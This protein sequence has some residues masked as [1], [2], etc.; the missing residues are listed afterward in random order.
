[1]S[2]SL[3]DVPGQAAQRVSVTEPRPGDP[4][5]LAIAA[6]AVASQLFTNVYPVSLGAL[7]AGGRATPAQLGQLASVEYLFMAVTALF[8]ARVFPLDRLRQVVIV[9]SVAQFTAILASTMLTGNLFLAVRAVFA[10]ACGVQIWLQYELIGRSAKPGRLVG[11]C[12]V[13]VVVSALLMSSLA[14]RFVL[15]GFG[16]N[17]MILFFGLPSLVAVL[18]AWWLP[19]AIDAAA[20]KAQSS[21]A[22]RTKLS[23]GSYWILLSGLAW[24]AWISILWVFSEPLSRSFGVSDSASHAFVYVSLISSLAGAALGA[25][26]SE[27]ISFNWA[28][29]LGLTTCLALVV[30]FLAGVNS[31]AYII[32]SSVFGF[33]GYFLVPFFVK[34]LVAADRSGH[35]VGLFPAMQYGGACL[36]PLAASFLVAPGQYR[37]GLFATLASILLAMGAYWIGFCGQRRRAT[38]R[39]A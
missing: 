1:M 22:H 13:T 31:V 12:I 5:F 20:S 11:A 19:R 7:E 39:S 14:A 25:L 38:S 30:S 33:L 24:S 28:L 3:S 15:P 9:V 6:L 4:P 8:V 32:W 26:L 16:I 37:G 10:S 27:R 29:S 34:A 23:S 18:A 2:R 21:A 17:G 35:S 36:G